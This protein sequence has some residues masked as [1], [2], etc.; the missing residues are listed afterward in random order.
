MNYLTEKNRPSELFN[1]IYPNDINEKDLHISLGEI[2]NLITEATTEATKEATRE[3][4]KVIVEEIRKEF[5]EKI[6]AI[7]SAQN[8]NDVQKINIKQEVIGDKTIYAVKAI[9]SKSAKMM[10]DEVELE[11][12]NPLNDLLKYYNPVPLRERYKAAAERGTNGRMWMACVYRG[13]VI[14]NVLN[15]LSKDE[16]ANKL[17]ISHPVITLAVKESFGE[18]FLKIFFTAL[19][20]TRKSVEPEAI[21]NDLSL[22]V[23]PFDIDLDLNRI[24]SQK[25]LWT[26]SFVAIF[27]RYDNLMNMGQANKQTFLD[28]LSA[29]NTRIEVFKRLLYGEYDTRTKIADELEIAGSTVTDVAEECCPGF[30]SRYGVKQYKKT[31]LTNNT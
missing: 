1:K 12:K 8:L 27:D 19:T 11:L 20:S 7:N 23:H 29:Y 6:N 26:S 14:L 30:R 4:T 10:V 21:E 22:V 25:Y 2:K 9:S 18:Q 3:A 5:N 24:K 16:I 28:K 13:A 17:G 31:K 15:G